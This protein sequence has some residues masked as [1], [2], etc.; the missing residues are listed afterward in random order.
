MVDW[1]YE[2]PNQAIIS[3]Q[4]SKFSDKYDVYFCRHQLT[5]KLPMLETRQASSDEDMLSGD[6]VDSGGVIGSNEEYAVNFD[7]PGG[8]S[9]LVL[10]ILIFSF[11]SL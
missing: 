4:Q 1:T 6:E 11:P 9:N 10:K 7:L 2:I 5:F 8:F 3:T